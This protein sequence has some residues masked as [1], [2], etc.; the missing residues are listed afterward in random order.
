MFFNHDISLYDLNQLLIIPKL[1]HLPDYILI[2]I[3]HEL[4]NDEFFK[5]N[6]YEQIHNV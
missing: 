3:K 1:L 6:K 5:Q 4:R 2:D